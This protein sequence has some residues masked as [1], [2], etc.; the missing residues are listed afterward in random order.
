[1][2]TSE[3]HPIVHQLQQEATQAARLSG[4]AISS[5]AWVWPFRGILYAIAHPHVILSVRSALIKSLVTSAI[6]FIALA[7]FTYVPQAAVL[8]LFTGPI[9]GPI[10]ALLLLGAESIF[11]MTFFARA[12]FLEPA[13]TQVFDTTLLAKGQT[14]LV[15]TGKTK[16]AAGG[17]G[18]R[19]AIEGA[20]VRPFQALSAN[21]VIKYLVSLPLNFVP[22]IGTVAFLFLNGQRGGPGWHTRYF[23]L[24]G[25]DKQ[26]RLR[27]IASRR[28]EYT[29][30]GMAT[31]F[32]TFI[33][34]VGLVFSFTNTV[35]AA[36]WAAEMEAK[37]N[38]IDP[39][40]SS[41]PQ[42][43]IGR[44]TGDMATAEDM[45]KNQ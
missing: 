27:F 10:L 43:P 39:P 41:A 33:P 35:G 44:R 45:K 15:K 23:Q 17:G 40:A 1:M 25:W 7:I 16:F 3:V 8:S 22:V 6:S 37:A 12:L 28:A 36:L 19:E 4:D 5:F 9:L 26:Q 21:G 29:A 2:S 30:F 24:K 18:K 34:V 38:I 20:V 32:F 11:L 13:L 14:E 42:P 31:L